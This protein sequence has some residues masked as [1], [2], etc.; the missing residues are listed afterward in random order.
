MFCFSRRWF[1]QA[2]F[3][4]KMLWGFFSPMRFSHETSIH[5]AWILKHFWLTCGR[6][7]AIPTMLSKSSQTL[8]YNTRMQASMRAPLLKN[9]N[10]QLKKIN[11]LWLCFT[12]IRTP[13]G[14]NNSVSKIKC[15]PPSIFFTTSSSST[16]SQ[17]FSLVCVSLILRPSPVRILSSSSCLHSPS[18]LS[19]LPLIARPLLQF[20]NLHWLLNKVPCTH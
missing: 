19:L 6:I 5:K 18:L 10:N 9:Y 4:A 3:S 20:R 7:L 12:F 1:S 17:S 2:I 8:Y 14:H 13:A 16:L 15:R 11:S